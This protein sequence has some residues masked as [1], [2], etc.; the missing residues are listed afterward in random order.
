MLGAQA[1]SYLSSHTRRPRFLRQLHR[2]ASLS[3]ITLVAFCLASCSGL[4]QGKIEDP[5]SPAIT[6]SLS[7]TNPSVQISQSLN[8][9]ATIQNDPSGKGVTWSLS[10]AGCSGA[11]CGTLSN[12]TI[13]SVTYSAP[14]TAPSPATVTIKATSGAD[15]SISATAAITITSPAIS[16]SVN[17][18]TS[19][20][21]LTKSANFAAT[22]QNDSQSK[23]VTWTLSGTGCSG[24]TCGTLTNVTTTSVTYSAPATMT[25]PDTVTLIGTSVADN[26]KHAS[27]II[28][29]TSAPLP[30]SVSM[31]PTSGF[32]QVSHSTGFTAAVQND[33]ANNG[34]SWSLSGSGCSGASCGTLT[35]ATTTSVTYTA[36]ATAPSPASVTLTAKSV[37]DATKSASASITVTAA[38]PPISVS[39]SPVSASVQVSKS[40]GFTA[41]VQNDSANKGVAWTLSGSGCSGAT[42]GTLTNATTTSVT[43]NAPSSVPS[44]A[45]VILKATSVSDG[46]KSASAAITVTPAPLP[47][48][49][50]V[51][52]TSASVQTSQSAGFTATV[53][54]DSANK[55]VLWSLSGTG[56]SGASCGSLTNITLTSVTY[57]APASVP[58]PPSVVLNATAISD[59]TKSASAAITVIAAPP[60]ISV[61]LSPTSTSVQVSLSTGFTATV[62]NDSANK[63][64]TWSLSGSGC[65]GATCGT[66][67]VVTSSSVTYNAPA[68]VPTPPTVTIKATSVADATKSGSASITV[69]A[70]PPPISV[71]VNPT[72]ASVLIS[73]TSN[74]TASVQNDSA[75]KGVTWA[76]SGSGCSGSACG[77]LSN[78]TTTSVTYTAPPVAPSPDTVTLT[79]TS[80][81]NGTKSASASITVTAATPPISVSISPTSASLQVSQSTGFTSS[82]QND[83]TNSGVS[84]SL[85]GS[86]CSG[87]SCGTLSNISTSAVTYTAPSAVPTPPS[88]SLTATSISDG[89]KSASVSIDITS[90]SSQLKLN[91]VTLFILNTLSG[92]PQPISATKGNLIVVS[93]IG[94]PGDNLVNVSDNK[95]NTY[96]STGQ[97]GT[98][99]D[100]GEC[101]IFYA[102]NATP[103]VTSITFT[104]STNGNFDD[105]DVYDVSGASSSPF[106]VAT[107]INN[108]HETSFGNISGPS[109][110]APNAG[111]III[112]NVGVE[113]NA[114]TGTNSPWTFDPQDQNNG[115][116]H[117]LNSSSGTFTVTWTTNQWETSGGIGFW[118]GIAAAFK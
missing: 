43:Y 45:S 26:S 9:S 99:T 77:A 83:S 50:S 82:V 92:V 64:V 55:G 62:Q 89:T 28:T 116:A 90:P 68:T 24:N 75:N 40:T 69:M 95:G 91:G 80:V 84:W 47:I 3:A 100:G 117:V 23:G 71:S 63:G 61:S 30:I 73:T 8:F 10:G 11:A 16:V 115:W 51:S 110:T 96:V 103:G 60:P 29:L 21:Q 1:G 59:G 48:S 27:A 35:N 72:S 39:V 42:C 81:S 70:A 88:V 65:S 57:N 32:V 37:S 36:P 79:A 102:A 15:S 86:G 17:P 22:L 12:V 111:G 78:V 56:C 118:G 76:L 25:N 106:D 13:S 97:H 31:N 20:I 44:P 94:G 107:T 19:S 4:V 41:T 49:V 66:L 112:A 113:T 105:A 5:S 108:Q 2:A 67:T 46:T 18:P 109:I 6:V 101:F 14:S 53:Q 85:S 7:L 58:A 114:L 38:P 87:A 52:P 104:T 93:Y 98:S 74:F 54:N 33:S 34:V